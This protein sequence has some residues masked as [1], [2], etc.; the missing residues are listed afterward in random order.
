MCI[1]LPVS[2]QFASQQ[3]PFVECRVG[4]VAIVARCAIEHST[5][6]VVIVVIGGVTVTPAC[7]G[8]RS[9]IGVRVILVGCVSICPACARERI[10]IDIN[11]DN[12][13]KGFGI[14]VL[15]D[16][17]EVD[18]SR[19]VYIADWFTKGGDDLD[20]LKHNP[21]LC[22]CVG[23][24]PHYASFDKEHFII[25]EI[26]GPEGVAVLLSIILDMLK[27]KPVSVATIPKLQT[28]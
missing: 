8:E 6:R 4:R 1:D 27:V 26:Q 7:T 10:T 17:E 25:S 2:I 24:E 15:L 18:I 19:V 21:G 3:S 5:I 13:D 11:M 28:S 16:Q 23:D 12:V 9:P 14:Q 22:L 20:V